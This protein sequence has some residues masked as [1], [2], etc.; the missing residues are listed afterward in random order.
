[1]ALCSTQV[2]NI[3]HG[4]S[5]AQYAAACEFS[6][7]QGGAGR[8]K[9]Q[10]AETLCF[11][12]SQELIRDRYGKVLTKEIALSAIGKRPLESWAV[13]CEQL[14]LRATAQELLDQSEP[15]LRD[16]CCFC[17][18]FMPSPNLVVSFKLNQLL[19][20][21][22]HPLQFKILPKVR[23]LPAQVSTLVTRCSQ[24]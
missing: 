9:T 6:R 10:R 14:G 18:P 20:F 4:T 16:R 12:I 22:K 5:S 3:L 2:R 21:V 23:S 1:M 15:L 24:D 7:I 17:P 8:K 13:V 19:V 11:Q